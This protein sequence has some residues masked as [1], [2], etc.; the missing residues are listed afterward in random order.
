M[1]NFN[2]VNRFR[3]SL[4]FL[5]LVSC[6]Q[7]E[8]LTEAEK[9]KIVQEAKETLDN[10]YK[11]IRKEGLMAE[12]KYLDNSADFF[13]IPPGYDSP[14]SYD[15]IA[16]ILNSNAAL[17]KSVENAFDTLR[18]IPL[19]NQLVTYTGRLHSVVTDTSGKTSH[20]VLVETGTLIKRKG[21]W[22]LLNGQT[23]LV[24]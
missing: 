10:Y 4:A 21:G 17:L 3:F 2:T 15:S 1:E 11:D 9:N 18:I 13:W 7:P 19:T 14:L 8:T 12:F 23:N 22:K 16:S 5:F 6:A 20:H 24:K